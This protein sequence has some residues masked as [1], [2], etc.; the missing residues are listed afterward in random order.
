MSKKH[1]G[2]KLKSRGTYEARREKML[3]RA[4]AWKARNALV[5]GRKRR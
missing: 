1:R 4:E 3:E 2:K 5:P